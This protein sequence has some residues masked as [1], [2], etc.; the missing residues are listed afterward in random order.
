M[1]PS[2]L[3]VVSQ[4]LPMVYSLEDT[5]RPSLREPRSQPDTRK[6]LQHSAHGATGPKRQSLPC[7]S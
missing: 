3:S 7:V 1:F 5:F 4:L 2:G 6:P